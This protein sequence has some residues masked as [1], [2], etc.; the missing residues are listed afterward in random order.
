MAVIDANLGAIDLAESLPAKFAQT[1][2]SIPTQVDKI[3]FVVGNGPG[4]ALAKELSTAVEVDAEHYADASKRPVDDL[5]KASA[6][7]NPEVVIGIGGG[8]V[9]DMSKIAAKQAKAMHVA[10]PTVLSQDGLYATHAVVRFEDTVERYKCSP[11][12]VVLAAQEQINAAPNVFARS[13]VGDIL[14]NYSALLDCKLAH[15]NGI[16]TVSEEAV[17]LSRQAADIAA[18]WDI[19]KPAMELFLAVKLSGQAMQAAGDSAPC[20]GAEH[21]LVTA[22][23]KVT[24]RAIPHGLG[25]AL[26]TVVVAALRSEKELNNTI[27]LASKFNLPAKCSDLD[28]TE[29]EMVEALVLASELRPSRFTVLDANNFTEQNFREALKSAEHMAELVES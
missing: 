24:N 17:D 28:I 29:D 3:M 20:S 23:E 22:L 25:V 15:A 26:C 21:K 27:Q 14:S 12:D 9:I 10:I 18:N 1:I 11:P 8:A 16:Y 5:M 7:M 13:C 4:V 6:D 19:E 2:A